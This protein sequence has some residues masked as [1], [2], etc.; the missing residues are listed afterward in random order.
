MKGLKEVLSKTFLIDWD[1]VKQYA[2]E[3]SRYGRELQQFQGFR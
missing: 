1:M 2:S 3:R